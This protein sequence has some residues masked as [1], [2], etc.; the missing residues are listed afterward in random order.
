MVLSVEWRWQLI[1]S[2]PTPETNKRLRYT[3]SLFLSTHLSVSERSECEGGRNSRAGKLFL[4]DGLR[5]GI[6]GHGVTWRGLASA[7]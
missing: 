5:Q 7:G 4:Y 1:R 3:M 6:V 2:G